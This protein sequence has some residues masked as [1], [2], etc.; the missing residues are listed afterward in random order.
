MAVKVHCSKCGVFIKNAEQAEIQ[1]LTGKEICPECNA[2]IQAVFKELDTFE[3]KYKEDIKKLD[4]K[5]RQDMAS[6]EKA[7]VRLRNDG[8]GLFTTIKAELKSITE[9]LLE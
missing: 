8:Q 7:I 4:V 5:S 3:K 6:F 2:R 9:N 1:K